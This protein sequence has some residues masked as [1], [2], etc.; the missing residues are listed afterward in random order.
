MSI[1][2]IQGT[3]YHAPTTLALDQGTGAR[4]RATAATGR[5]ELASTYDMHDG[6]LTVNGKPFP[7]YIEEDGPRVE[8]LEPG[9]LFHVLWLPVLVES[10]LPDQVREKPGSPIEENR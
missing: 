8:A 4:V 7:Y 9:A 10:P 5:V 6:T 1:A 3:V 2:P